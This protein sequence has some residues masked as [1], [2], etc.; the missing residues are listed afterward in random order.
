MAVS[1]IGP[2]FYAW[3]R[4][5]K[6]LAFGK[7]YTYQA[8]TNTPRSTF[9]SEDAA[10]ENTNPVVLNGEGYANIYLD[11]SYKIV[12]KD[13][14]DNEIWT[15]DPVSAS[16]GEEW[17]NC[18]TATYL[19]S[20]TF[21]I[22]G[23]VTDTFEAGRRVRVNNNAATYSYSTI[24]SAVFAGPDTTITLNSEAVT[25]GLT[26]V[27]TSIIG[28]QSLVP[29][30]IKTFADLRLHKSSTPWQKV[31]VIG[32]TVPGVG[33]DP[34][35]Y[36]PDDTTSPDNNGTVIINQWG[37]RWKRKEKDELSL[38]DFGAIENEGC[39]EA[40]KA[41]VKSGVVVTGQGKTY[42]ILTGTFL[43]VGLVKIK[44]KSVNF[45][46][47]AGFSA[48]VVE[49]PYSDTGLQ[50]N[51]P[52]IY[53]KQANNV[54][55]E[56]VYV[57]G[58]GIIQESGVSSSLVM[59]DRC[60]NVNLINGAYEN[61]VGENPTLEGGAVF[62]VD[63]IGVYAN[64]VHLEN[65]RGEGIHSR[66]HD[67]T[68]VDCT[69]DGSSSS[70]IGSQRLSYLDIES[71]GLTVRGGKYKNSDN[72]AVSANSINSIIDGVTTIDSGI[73][74]NIGHR[75]TFARRASGSKSKVINCDVDNCVLYGI[76][77]AYGGDVH[78]SHNTVSRVGLGTTENINAGIRSTF[79]GYSGIISENTVSDCLT[80]IYVNGTVSDG[81]QTE[82]G[83][84]KIT[85]N[86][87]RNI[88]RYALRAQG[89]EQLHVK[90]NTLINF[91]TDLATTRAGIYLENQ[92]AN[93]CV[94]D[95]SGNILGAPDNIMGRGI[96]VIMTLP[97]N[98][99]IKLHSNTVHCTDGFFGD[100]SKV[101]ML[102]NTFLGLE[103]R[104]TMPA[105]VGGVADIGHAKYILAS[106]ASAVSVDSFS[107]KNQQGD[108]ITV[109]ASNNN[110]TLNDGAGF[111]LSSSFS[112]STNDSITLVWSGGT[113]YELA[114]SLN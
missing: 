109:V 52:M 39:S 112:M 21:K 105:V 41:A 72:T 93:S 60:L 100:R 16:G 17:V 37:E 89:V 106:P 80:G 30:T 94:W 65:I 64:K 23:N 2:K 33:G 74:I 18:M 11:G 75:T 46:T 92:N 102:G 71:I 101:D 8:R 47:T 85:G 40:L 86:T 88:V 104:Y 20:T 5:G 61:N 22:T 97:D 6:P 95:I 19:T 36:D 38:A 7:V 13:K 9:Q 59:F 87:I 32:H 26:N 50:K 57:D 81:D 76:N 49:T 107:N 77:S 108:I 28:N 51:K 113:Y 78:I 114:R 44:I 3:D 69:G 42:K 1:I 63:C 73:G 45:T 90:D 48:P 82:L 34:F 43:D 53:V 55:L 96:E 24:E 12:V 62:L 84:F 91:A 83:E 79:W 68:I 25:T 10:V 29:L 4:N 99:L 67:V 35:F 103:E 110:T 27:C 14:D 66:S 70:L 111:S 15:A 54:T 31:E 56:D 98:Y 58:A